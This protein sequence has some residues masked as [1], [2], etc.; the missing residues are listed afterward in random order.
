MTTITAQKMNI[1]TR[2][3]ENVVKQAQR[4]LFEFETLASAYEFQSGNFK[5]YKSVGAL[6]RDVK[7]KK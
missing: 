6:L 1:A 2:N 5:K 4:R 7:N 3:L